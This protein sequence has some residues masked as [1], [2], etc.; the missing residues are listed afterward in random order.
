[1]SEGIFSEFFKNQAVQQRKLP[2]S[3]LEEKEESSISTIQTFES[4]ITGISPEKIIEIQD[5]LTNLEKEKEE[6]L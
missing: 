2:I 5:V 6:F 4:K 3:V 1:M